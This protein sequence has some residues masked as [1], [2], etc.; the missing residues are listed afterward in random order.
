MGLAAI[1]LAVLPPKLPAQAPE[2]A[3]ARAEV[4]RAARTSAPL[5][6]DGVLDEPAWLTADSITDF[7]QQEPDEGRPA[8]E[9]TVVRILAT[10]EGIYLGF[11]LYQPPGRIV[12]S[13]LRRDSDLETDDFVAFLLDPQLD[14]RSA[15]AF[16]VN[17]NGA[18]AEGEV[19][20]D[21]ADTNWDGVWD[22]RARITSEGWVAEVFVPWQTLRYPRDAERWGLNLV[23]EIRGKNEA[24]MW[25]SWQRQF[26]FFYLPGEGELEGLGPL[27]PR[28]VVEARPYAST[29][30]SLAV[31]EYRA[32]ATDSVVS[33]SEADLAFGLDAKV[34]VSGTLTLDLTTHTDFAQVEAD[35]QVV[36]LSR[37]PLFFPEKRPFFLES[38]A[39]FDFG[40][41]E[42][43]QLFHSR[44][45]G[46]APD[47]T[48]IPIEAGARL[49]GRVGHDRL[50][51]LAVRTGGVEDAL[52][53]VARVKH[54]VFARGYVGGMLTAQGGPGVDGERLAYGADFNFP[55][56]LHQQNIVPAAFVA[57]SLDGS[58]APARSAWRAFLD[59][60]NDWA[61]HFVA[62]SR[63]ENG[64]DPAL[65][66]VRQNGVWRYTAA[67][68]FAPRPHRWGL[69]NFSF[70]PIEFDISTDLN[71][72]LNNGFYEVRPFGFR[73]IA[74]DE[75][76]L[77]LQRYEDVPSDTFEIFPGTTVLP[78]RYAWNRAE[79]QLSTAS[80][81]PVGFEIGVSAGDYYTGS[82][83]DVQ[84]QLAV[85]AAP[86]VI[87]VL[88]GGV[89]RVRLATGSFTTRVAR[90]RLDYAA[91]PRLATT[92]FLQ[93]DNESERL[94]VNARLHWI[95]RPG[96]DVYLVWN[97]AWPMDL[98]GGVPWRRPLRG[99][100]VGKVVYYFR[101]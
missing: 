45:I 65:G 66:F 89:Q 100:L 15:Y 74:G 54:D 6:L 96:S 92:A 42:R 71:G 95:P 48:P 85:R 72:R 14:H 60:P 21:D 41:I 73:T 8:T 20:G 31:R 13:Q 39:V 25:R 34:A 63:I 23:R 56:L 37:F 57:W 4:A 79:V 5:R 11:W 28:R 83:S 2:P 17:A 29:T 62:I 51:L 16:G 53:L 52:D 81:R 12:R 97:S 3:P 50:G 68:R 27:P 76:E 99:A 80:S 61:D 67:L 101:V 47:G 78:G 30:G 59:Y 90:L 10:D 75:F 49:S 1:A 88:D 84:L 69:R 98:A 26:G 58:G 82:G 55:L 9:R 33:G 24:V 32:D 93:Y 7:R 46:L 87:G 43:T 70:K 86:H 36:N 19:K 18:M 77:N 38:S 22:A 64:F 91:T 44:R 35:R 94:A 40:Q